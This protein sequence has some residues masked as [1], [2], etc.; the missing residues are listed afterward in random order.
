MV[1]EEEPG[2]CRVICFSPRHDLTL[3][4]MAVADIERVVA[5]WREQYRELGAMDG[6]NAVQIFENRGEMMGASNPHPH[7]QV[8]ATRIAAQRDGQG[9]R[10][11]DRLLARARLAAA[12][13]TICRL[14]REA[15]ERIVFEND[16]FHR[17]G[18]VLGDL[19][20]RDDGAAAAARRP[21][22]TN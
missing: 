22:S 18:A 9:T 7:C 2:I 4:R 10:R 5:V 8:W 13:S 16:A 12:L 14:E 21:R 6:I 19:A 11:A 15:G 17:A 20:V 1:A 3:A